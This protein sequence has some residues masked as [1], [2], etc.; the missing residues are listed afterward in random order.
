MDIHLSAAH[1][2][3]LTG[4]WEEHGSRRGAAEAIAHRLG[5][6]IARVRRQLRALGLQRG[7]L[8]P[9]Q[10]LVLTH[11]LNGYSSEV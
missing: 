7:R 8:T 6:P 3:Q 9:A 1:V 4:L 11:L 10:V 5:L 2:A